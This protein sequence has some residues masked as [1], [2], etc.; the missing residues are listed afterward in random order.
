MKVIKRDG[1]AVDFDRNKIEIAIEKANKEVREK[2]RATKAEIK[3][4]INYISELDRKRILVE[5]I[6]DII[7]EQLMDLKHFELAKKYMIYRYTRALVRKS[8]STDQSILGLIKNQNKDLYG[9][10]KNSNT[11]VASIQRDLIAGEVS[12]DLTKRILLPEKIAKAHEE[13]LLYFHD[14]DYFLQPIFNSCIIN[15]GDMLD[16]E[17]TMNGILIETPKS[18]Q[19]A[20][21]VAT[22][23]IANVASAQYGGQ[24]VYI[25]HLGKYL[26]KSYEKIKNELKEYKNEL[27]KNTIEK[28]IAQRLQTELSSGVQ[29]IQYQINTL[30]TTNGKPPYV[31]L[32]LYLEENDEYEKENSMII[33]EILKQRIEGIKNENK[34]TITIQ[35]PRLVYVLDENNNLNG[36]KYDYL[37]KL[38]LKCAKQRRYPEFI[39]AKIMRKNYNGNVFP[40]VGYK[41]FL[42]PWKEKSGGYKFE[43]RFN[44]GTVTINLPQI[45]LKVEGE[46]KEF[47]K[48]LDE[49][50]KICYEALMCKHYALLGT[51]TDV[52][53]IH[54]I[55]G[56]ISRLSSG[57]KIDDLLKNGYSTIC[58]GYVGIYETVKLLMGDNYNYIEGK[59]IA[60]NIMKRLKATVDGWKK[61]T[62]LGFVLYATSGANVCKKFANIDLENYGKIKDIT[63]KEYYN[64]SY[65]FPE[66]D[67]YSDFSQ[68]IRQEAEFQ[69]LSLGGAITKL[70]ISNVDEAELDNIIKLIYDNVQ[71]V[72]FK[73]SN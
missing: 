41:G 39:S 6:Q 8:N 68:K 29:T 38:A 52:S 27:P 43:G 37:T 72:E 10:S 34:E 63:D 23:I 45:A 56:A 36:G 26:R 46:E 40:P 9:N 19:V 15:L 60:L 71:Y 66:D 16:N 12:K 49:R 25:S 42:S 2:D 3:E 73:G 30:M 14:S 59:E 32:F 53:P 58:L 62:G 64:S 33:E 11:V 20:C 65:H 24:T 57:E 48:E 55:Y 21:T 31:T 5:D 70:D 35:F 67:D 44:Q 61:E 4:I 50:L 1:R 7:E 22:Q 13:G 17:T 47:W 18:F 69:N 54:Y 51:T 28:M